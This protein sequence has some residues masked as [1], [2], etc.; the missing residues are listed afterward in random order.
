[1]GIGTPSNHNNMPLPKPMATSHPIWR[2][3]QRASRNIVPLADRRPIPKRKGSAAWPCSVATITLTLCLILAAP[4]P[5]A[6][7][8]APAEVIVATK[9]A[10][11]FAMKGEDGQWTGIAIE[12][13]GRIADK[14]GM[15]STFKEYQTVPEM[16]S[17][18]SDGS[19][20]AAISAITVTSD[21]EKTVDFSQPYYESGLGV[22]VPANTE[23]E[24]FSILRGIFTPRF[25]EA[26]GILIAIA[27]LVG[28][29]IWFIERHHTEHYSKDAKGLGT[30]LWWSASAMTQA[31]AADKA[32]ATLLGRLLGM[33]WMIASIIIIAS[34]TAGITSQLAARRLESAVR[35][36]AD[37]AVV[38]TGT[39]DATS[40]LQYLQSQRIDARIYPTVEDGLRA[41]KAGKL[42]AFVYDRPI[43][44][45]NRRKDFVDDIS[46][47]DK[48]FAR[49][50]YAIAL[51]EN[52]PLRTK[53]DEAML[54]DLRSP[55]WQDV[56]HRYLGGD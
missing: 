10:P 33:L 47:L 8:A 3:Q 49:E 7:A 24:W 21:R 50:N 53:I 46:V 39:V 23:I 55:W 48:L 38:R 12:L 40:A 2:A 54:D 30:G 45:W 22:A 42:D 6:A 5:P 44:E 11:P 18:V 41:L 32:P 52:S 28:S 9:E 20:N 17:A 1:M 25:F 31:A 13:W 56:V 16:L 34:F 51:P 35:T 26:V 29:L 4:V 27:V 19:A 15:H 43:L 14:L 37:L 36:S